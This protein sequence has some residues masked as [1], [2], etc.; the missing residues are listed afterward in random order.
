VSGSKENN[1]D[2]IEVRPFPK[3]IDAAGALTEALARLQPLGINTVLIGGVALAVYGIERYTK[4]VDLAIT[5]KDLARV[6]PLLSHQ[7]PRPLRIGGLSFLTSLG[8]R[9]D[10]IDRRV[11]YQALFEELISVANQ[12]GLLTRLG[13][14]EVRVAPLAY[15]VALKMIADRPQDEL[16]LQRILLLQELDY[17]LTR[18]IIQ[19]HLGP[20]AA[21][22]LDKLARAAGRKEPPK[23]YSPE[24]S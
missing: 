20:Y 16:D 2:P 11:S 21:E 24:D 12:R 10:L 17:A 15:L 18:D 8:V 3:P 19:R 6:A 13:D 9:V 1:S 14:Q 23:E 7:D 4:D 5:M 22:R